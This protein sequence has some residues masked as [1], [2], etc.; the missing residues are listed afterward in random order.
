[1]STEQ[2]EPVPKPAPL[3]SRSSLKNHPKWSAIKQ[4]LLTGELSPRQVCEKFGL[5]LTGG[6]Y[7]IT[8][9]LRARAQT[10]RKYATVLQEMEAM[11]R[12]ALIAEYLE[13]VRKVRTKAARGFTIAEKQI[14]LDKEGN[15]IP[16]PD[17]EAMNAFLETELNAIEKLGV[18][19]GLDPEG[20]QQIA[21]P[22][23]T[24]GHQTIQVMAMPRIEG[25]Q[26]TQSLPQAKVL[27]IE[28][29]KP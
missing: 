25:S 15:Q 9:V 20:K 2:V 22:G 8:A 29:V 18:A 3:H 19:G 12:S 6:G 13:S 7:A 21:A 4:V 26:M 11:E 5:R 1:M 23:T 14:K 16:Q 17:F 28:S 10:Q 27:E 24:I